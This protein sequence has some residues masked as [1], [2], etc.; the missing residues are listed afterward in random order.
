MIYFICRRCA[1]HFS[2]PYKP[3]KTSSPTQYRTCGASF[4]CAFGATIASYAKS[5]FFDNCCIC[6]SVIDHYDYYISFFIRSP[7]RWKYLFYLAT[8]V[9][10]CQMIIM[11]YAVCCNPWVLFYPWAS[12]FFLWYMAH[13]L[14]F[15]SIIKKTYRYDVYKRL[16]LVVAHRPPKPKGQVQ[17]LNLLKFIFYFRFGVESEMGTICHPRCSTN[18]LRKT[19]NK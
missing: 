17:I 18:R 12:N 15:H 10:L 4:S 19:K 7:N 6:S 16:V 9:F 13:S 2:H 14:G 8:I 5:K 3:P 1:R 11:A